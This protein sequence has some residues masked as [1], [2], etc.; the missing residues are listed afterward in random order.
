MRQGAR[1][2]CRLD[3]LPRGKA[4]APTR[5]CAARG[6]QTIDRVDILATSFFVEAR[7]WTW[8]SPSIRGFAMG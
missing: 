6:L 8:K 5:G 3:R 4:F 1:A 2:F 7:V